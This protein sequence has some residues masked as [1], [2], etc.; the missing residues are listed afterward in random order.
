MVT[1]KTARRPTHTCS[2][3]N[4]IGVVQTRTAYGVR[5]DPCKCRAQEIISKSLEYA[6]IPKKYR[7]WDLRSL[8]QDFRTLNVDPLRLVK[9]YIIHLDNNINHAKGLWFS[10]P[11]GA[12][13]SSIISYILRNALEEGYCAYYIK[14]HDL[15]DLRMSAFRDPQAK[16]T[17]KYI[18]EDVQILALEDMEKTYISGNWESYQNITFFNMLSDIVDSNIALL[19]SS[20]DTRDRVTERFPPYIGASFSGLK[21]VIFRYHVK[22]GN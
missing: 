7:N 20:N 12:A 19:V 1:S 16:D 6:N 17:I 18:L 10:S 21:D 15:H 5:L 14:A 9:Q 3:C 13:K 11:P 4:G 22:N 2:R 8:T